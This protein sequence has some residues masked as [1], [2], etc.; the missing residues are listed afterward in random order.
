VRTKRNRVFHQAER[1]SHADAELAINVA[2]A[3]VG[4]LLP[5]VV[6]NLGLHFHGTRLCGTNHGSTF[7]ASRPT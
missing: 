5:T 3:F 6:A 7:T 2:A 1:A 4:D